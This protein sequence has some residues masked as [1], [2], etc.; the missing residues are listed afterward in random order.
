M[1][2][3]RVHYSYPRGLTDVERFWLRVDKGGPG[4]CWLWTGCIGTAGYGFF[5]TGVRQANAHRFAYEAAV[6][7]IPDGMQ[8]DHLCR[9]RRCVNP[10]HLE[11]V[12]SRENT[13]RGHGPAALNARQTHCIRG[14]EFT[15][16]N[17]YVRSNRSRDCRECKRESRRKR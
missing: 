14:H 16:E 17:T 13:L 12:S 5:Y 3:C 6:G 9:V 1:G 15:P 10:G 8:L 4:G 7:P 2:L 11:A